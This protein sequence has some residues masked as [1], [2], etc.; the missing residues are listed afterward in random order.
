[1]HNDSMIILHKL[2]HISKELTVLVVLVGFADGSRNFRKLLSI[3]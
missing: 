3:S 1:M 2:C